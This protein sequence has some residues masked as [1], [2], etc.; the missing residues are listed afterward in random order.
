MST[1]ANGAPQINPGDILNWPILKIKY[2]TDADKVAALLPPGITPAKEPEVNVRIYNFPVLNE[3]EYGVVVSVNA[4]YEG[5]PGE[6]TLGI[7]IDQEAAIYGSQERW[8]Q[9]KYFANTR[10]FR[11]GN[12]V[13]ASVT[14]QGRT[15]IEFRGQVTRSVEPPAPYEEH[16]WWIKC[17]RSVDPQSRSYD[18]PPHVVHVYSKYGT[19]YMEEVDGELVLNPSPWDPLATL[20]PL[21]KQLSAHLWTPIFLDRRITLAGKLDP[22]GFWPFADTIGG[23]RWP[24]ENGGPR[25]SG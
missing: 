9:P 17:L 2:L 11:L 19:A 25:K 16:E 15:F 8:G 20:L 18:F 13:E 5:T 23:S 12:H 1:P 3:P 4:D 14:H 21:R 24:G 6:Y 22:E 10:Y 7:G